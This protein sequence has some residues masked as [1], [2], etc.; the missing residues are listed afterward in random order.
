M[1]FVRS[2][3]R[4]LTAI[5]A[6]LQIFSIMAAA[7]DAAAVKEQL[8]AVGGK[9]VEKGG[10]ITELTIT[11][12]KKLGPAEFKLIGQVTSLKKLTLYGGCHGLNDET[13]PS[14]A[15]LKELEAIGTDGAKL[16]DDGLR[17]F[18]AFGN[19]KQASFFHTSFGMPGFT[20]VGFGHLKAC[21]NLERLTVAGISMG[22][23]GFAAIA[24]ITQ[25]KDFSTWHTY[26]T[27]AGNAHIAKL[28]NLRSL[29]LGQRL[30]GKD[31]KATSLS[32]IS[33]VT[34]AGMK[35]LEDLKI[36]EARFTLEG[37]KVLKG[38]PSLKTL[39]LYETDFPETGVEPLKQAL[40]TVKVTLDPLTEPQRKKLDQY[41]P[42]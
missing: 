23:D 13:L 6:S 5:F 12:C 10:A 25:L 24:T 33:L 14:L 17:H 16:T 18:A 22:D 9:V 15:G 35:T 41:V 11:D 2:M 21:P 3:H 40:P 20:G 30:P 8:V 4:H 26:Q 42:Q 39:L 28:P 19:L 31:R 32:D 7:D 37:V 38:L 1:A 29:K 34:I 36:G 27:E